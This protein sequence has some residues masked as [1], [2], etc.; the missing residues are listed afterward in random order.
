MEI[1]LRFILITVKVVALCI[2][3]L[4]CVLA[5]LRPRSATRLP[6]IRDPLLTLSV[7]DLRNKLKARQLSSV[8]LVNAYIKRI[9]DVNPKLNAVVED[10]FK[11]A[12]QEAR[13]IDKRIWEHAG[14]ADELFKEFPLLGMPF[15]IKESCALAGMSFAVGSTVR[16]HIR[17]DADGTVVA[18]LRAAGA[19][20]LLVSATPEYCYSVETDTLQ[21]RR[22]CNPY[23]LERSAGGSSGG[24]GALNGA[25][26]SV[27]GVGSDIG[28]SIRIPSLNCGIFGHKPTGGVV[29]TTGH[30][31]TSTD[32][33]FK[34]YLQLGPMS[35]FATDLTELLELMVGENLDKLLPA[36]QLNRAKVYYAMGFEGLN[37]LM[38]QSVNADIKGVLRKGLDHLKSLGLPVKHA[39]LPGMQNSL[40]IALSGIARLENM[41]YLMNKDGTLA[42]TL[43]EFLRSFLGLSK[44]TTNALIFELMRRA[45][46][47]MPLQQVSKYRE[48][49]L[50]L[51]EK[52]T[53]LLGK[54][55]VFIFPTMH[56]PASC[57]KWWTL[58]PL[59]GVDYT[60]IWNILGLPA[61]HVPMGLN[62]KGLPIGFSVIAGPYQDRLCINVA[63]ELERAFGGWQPPTPHNFNEQ[64]HA[65]T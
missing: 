50:A 11:T 18:R 38:H 59:W 35:R 3:P 15:T 23:D 4:Q 9:E 31:P 34:Q 37:G 44:H 60:L 46:A 49:A 61:T 24:E 42:K 51:T 16:S 27:F 53:Q 7:R 47:F 41:S 21:N 28:G 30:F 57:P 64:Q 1:L 6:S 19:I 36:V 54:D 62:A 5:Y 52:F 55:G 12:L 13:S 22:C 17:A 10:R 56:M 63:M 65:Q 14:H 40:E 25:G 43:L 39:R 58:L 8:D 26:A 20:P 32:E 2:Y 45:N 33:D 29:S 48:E